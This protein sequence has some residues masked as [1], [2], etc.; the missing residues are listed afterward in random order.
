LFGFP[1]KIEGVDGDAV[2]AQAGAGV[3][4]LEAE[5]LG[6][7]GVDDFVDVDAHLH[8]ELLEFVDQGDVD[9]AVYVLEELG[10]LGYGGRADWDYLFENCSVHGGG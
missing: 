3:E 7:G 4:G 5:G 8:A 6:F 10:H 9:A 2:A 1:R